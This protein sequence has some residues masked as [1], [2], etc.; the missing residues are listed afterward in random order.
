MSDRTTP[1]AT[2]AGQYAPPSITVLGPLQ[3]LTLQG[4]TFGSSD[5]MWLV[6]P[7]QSNQGLMNASG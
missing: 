6:I 1:S 5:Q 4:K 3:A 2:T 7:G